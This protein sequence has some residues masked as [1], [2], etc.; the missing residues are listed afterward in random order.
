MRVLGQQIAT[1]YLWTIAL[2]LVV[3]ATASY[4]SGSFPAPLSLA[5]LAAALIDVFVD[6]FYLKR[7]LRIPVSGIISGLIIGSVAP[8]NAPLLLVL[9]AVIFALFS[10]HFIRTKHGN[11]LNPSAFGLLIALFL[12]SV[13]DDWWAAANF[14]VYGLALTLTPILVIAAYKARRLTTSASFIAVSLVAD[15]AFAHSA[16]S[17]QGLLAALLG[18]N[19]FFAFV[20]AA[21][22][23]T[24]P[25]PRKLQALYGGGI[26]IVYLLLANYGIAYS[27]LIAL[28]AGNIAFLAYRMQRKTASL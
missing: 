1:M 9:F 26:A 22:P 4:V 6:K 19:F 27:L 20:M 24:S 5:V 16:M 12:F 13:G 15:I 17:L 18:I 7:Q 14:N 23:K 10:K 21:E 11:I 3:I 2:L 25:H 8:I 28:L